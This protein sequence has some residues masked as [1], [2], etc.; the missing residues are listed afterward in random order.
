MTSIVPRQAGQPNP[1]GAAD[2]SVCPAAALS[3]A[4]GLMALRL[5]WLPGVNCALALGAVGAGVLGFLRVVRSRGGLCGL[6]EAVSGIVL[7]VIVL[8]L[9]VFFVSAFVGAWR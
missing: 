6:D 9:S 8:G 2:R 5:C 4:L 1:A 3:F 7:G